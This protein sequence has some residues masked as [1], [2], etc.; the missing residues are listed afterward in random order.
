MWTITKP[1][2]TRPVAAITIFLPGLE[3]K[4]RIS[5]SAAAEMELDELFM[6]GCQEEPSFY[7]K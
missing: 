5:G 4:N 2:R 6:E 7:C 1:N 3:V